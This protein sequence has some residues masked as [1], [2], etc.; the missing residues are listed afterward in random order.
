M[1]EVQHDSW[2]FEPEQVIPKSNRSA[3]VG[4]P[5]GGMSI[6]TLNLCILE[7]PHW[8]INS[9]YTASY[10]KCQFTDDLL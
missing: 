4:L 8:C 7:Q 6:I 5:I 9:L 2:P 3:M 10:F 1:N